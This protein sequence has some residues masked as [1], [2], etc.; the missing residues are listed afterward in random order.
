MW[1]IVEKVPD[2]LYTHHKF[3]QTH[4]NIWCKYMPEANVIAAKGVQLHLIYTIYMCVCVYNGVQKSETSGE[5]AC[6][7]LLFNTK[8]F[9]TNYNQIVNVVSHF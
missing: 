2:F 4:S 1:L 6:F 8:F 3:S 9:T 7:V 5:N